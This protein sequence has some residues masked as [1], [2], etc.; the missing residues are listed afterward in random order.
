MSISPSSFLFGRGADKVYFALLLTCLI[1]IFCISDPF[2]TQHA[3]NPEYLDADRDSSRDKNIEAPHFSWKE[4]FEKEEQTLKTVKVANDYFPE[5][6]WIPP[7]V[8]GLD[9]ERMEQAVLYMK[10]I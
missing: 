3:E 6:Q 4:A 8:T 5:H 10:P 1:Y 7:K 9:E 2:P